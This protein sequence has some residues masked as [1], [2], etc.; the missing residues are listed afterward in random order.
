MSFTKLGVLSDINRALIEKGY[1]TPTPIQISAIPFIL[2]GFDLQASAQTGSGKTAA[3]GIPLIQNFLNRKNRKNIF[4]VDTLIVTPT[5]ELAI[6]IYENFKDFSKYVNIRVNVVYGGHKYEKQINK[7]EYGTDILIATPGRLLDF[8][9]QEI[10]KLSRITTFLLDEADL[11]LGMGFKK[12]LKKIVKLIPKERQTL[13]FSAT[14]SQ[15]ISEVAL[16]LLNNPKIIDETP[17]NKIAETIEHYVLYANND[18]KIE[19]LL[20]LMEIEKIEQ[21]ILFVRTRRKAKRLTKKLTELGLE[22]DTIHGDKSQSYRL[23]VLS[24]FKNNVIKFVVATDVLSRGIDIVKLEY[25]INFDIPQDPELY[26]HRIG[27]SGRAGNSGKAITFCDKEDTDEL[28]KIEKLIGMKINEYHN[29]S[30]ENE[31]MT[32]EKYQKNSKNNKDKSKMK[33]N[34]EHKISVI[35]SGTMG[36]GIAQIAATFG[37]KV[38]LIDQSQDALDKAHAKLSKI[39]A[40]LIEKGRMTEDERKAIFSRLNFTTNLNDVK[41]S[42]LVVEAIIENLEIKKQVLENVEQLTDEKTIIGTNTSSLSIASISGGLTRPENFIGIHFFNPAPLMPLVEVVPSFITSYE[43][44]SSVKELM[45][46][47]KKAPAIAKD[48][49]GFIV[50]RVARPFYAEAL[51]MYEEGMADIPTIDW[52]MKE[53]GGFKMG[54]FELMDFIGHDVNYVVTETVFREMYFD[55]RFRPSIAQ[56][57]LMEAGMNGRKSGR[58]FYDYSEDSSNKTEPNKDNVLGK[59]IFER[60]LALLVNEAADALF[61]N[62]ASREDID[63][64]MQKGVNYPKGLLAWGDEF[65]LDK[66]LAILDSLHD[67]Y[68]DPRYRTC[69]LLRKKAEKG[70]KFYS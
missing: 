46:D 16:D 63:K 34:K 35:G 53:F 5:R 41:G 29:S 43:V 7:L 37:H 66:I 9:K 20:K 38:E 1:S 69:P 30:L 24:E 56:K 58:G 45:L 31:N 14:M 36:N 3:F 21:A 67:L 40:R 68:L 48:T 62:V 23:S 54:P 55:P 32:S 8:A 10:V 18:Q 28:E 19:S 60:T 57:R 11:F 33:I 70:E 51:K 26:V 12:E 6:Q 65:G 61:M 25:I 49:P 15:D 47:W 27:R 4:Y 2:K 52:A 13:L 42:K 39:F 22:V 50:N 59:N 64:A 17:K 44:T